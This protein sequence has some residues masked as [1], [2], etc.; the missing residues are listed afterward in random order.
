MNKYQRNKKTIEKI[1]N[2]CIILW[3]KNKIDKPWQY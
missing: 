3:E 2:Q 1:Q